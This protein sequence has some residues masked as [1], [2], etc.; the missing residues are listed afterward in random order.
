MER[1]A[2][3]IS[4]I[5][6]TGKLHAKESG[7]PFHTIYKINSKLIKCLTIKPKT[8]KFLKKT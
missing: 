1:T 3:S 2:S 4:Y 5:G 6:K 7:L 8:I